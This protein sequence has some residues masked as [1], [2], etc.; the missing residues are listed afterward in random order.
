LNSTA[1]LLSVRGFS[2]VPGISAAGRCTEAARN[3]NRFRYEILSLKYFAR[4][5]I[6]PAALQTEPN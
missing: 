5:R 2:L 1:H 3:A 4:W 6:L